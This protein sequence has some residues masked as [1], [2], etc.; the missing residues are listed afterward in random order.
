MVIKV[1]AGTPKEMPDDD[2]PSFDEWMERVDRLCWR[3]VGL[4][5]QDLPDCRYWAWWDDRLRPVWAV[6]RAARHAGAPE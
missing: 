1:K 6:Q 4:S 3:L 2:R 5:I